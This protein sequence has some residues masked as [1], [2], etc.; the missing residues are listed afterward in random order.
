MV[1]RRHL[2][3]RRRIEEAEITFDHTSLKVMLLDLSDTG[4]RVTLYTPS[5]VPEVVS[6]RLP[7]G[8]IRV[9]C[10]RWQRNDEVGFEFLTPIAA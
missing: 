2:S 1:E 6:L 7:D 8:S 5:D 4:A 10:R 3:R 9:A